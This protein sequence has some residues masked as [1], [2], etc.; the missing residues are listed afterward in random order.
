M[1]QFVRAVLGDVEKIFV[2]LGK[3]QIELQI[4]SS[5]GLAGDFLG[6]WISNTD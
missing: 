6:G 1:G 2:Q 4:D 5:R 3:D